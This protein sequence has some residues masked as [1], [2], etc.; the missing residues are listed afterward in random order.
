MLPSWIISE[1]FIPFPR[2]RKSLIFRR[3]SPISEAFS[4][5]PGLPSS[6]PP[7]ALLGVLFKSYTYYQ[8]GRENLPLYPRFLTIESK[9]KR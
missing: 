9:R 6:A 8:V 3:F 4:L 1:V 7:S 2:W 5:V